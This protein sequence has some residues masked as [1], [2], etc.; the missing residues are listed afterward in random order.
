MSSS[1][2][3]KT[4]SF[5]IEAKTPAA[6]FQRMLENNLK[7]STNFTYFSIYSDGKKHIAWYYLRQEDILR[8]K[9]KKAGEKEA[10]KDK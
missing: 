4:I 8:E 6:L 10:A 3:D 1:A 7:N 5:F 9:A 2:F